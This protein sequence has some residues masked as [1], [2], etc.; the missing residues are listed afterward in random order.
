[1]P[2]SDT[3]TVTPALTKRQRQR[4]MERFRLLQPALE[5]GVP[6]AEAARARAIPYRTAKR[7]LRQ[8]RREGLAGL[9]RHP[10]RT[11]ASGACPSGWCT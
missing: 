7:W 3:A 11:G 9:V 6:L 1:M 10:A 8:Y 2:T 5:D 4:A